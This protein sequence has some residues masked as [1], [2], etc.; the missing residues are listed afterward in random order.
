MILNQTEEETFNEKVYNI[1]MNGGTVKNMENHF[2]NLIS[3]TKK[4]SKSILIIDEADV[5][6]NRE[7]L[8]E[9][10]SPSMNVTG[11][12]VNKLLD[13]IWSLKDSSPH[14]D[15]AVAAD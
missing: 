3:S 12:N 13:Y 9:V 14:P 2:S 15:D 10:Y 4:A 6:I 1:L 8:G 5:F 11:E 7:F